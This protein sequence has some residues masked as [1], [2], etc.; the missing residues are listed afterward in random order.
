MKMQFGLRLHGMIEFYFDNIIE[1]YE[2]VDWCNYNLKNGTWKFYPSV[3]S[4]ISTV[5]LTEH[6][7]AILFRLKFNA[8][9]CKT[10]QV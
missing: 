6:D 2:A 8:M 3:L 10:G 5:R 1:F 7:D 9:H 4:P